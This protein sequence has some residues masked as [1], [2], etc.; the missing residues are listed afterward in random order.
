MLCCW[1]DPLRPFTGRDGTVQHDSELPSC[2]P[3][4]CGFVDQSR[5]LTD[6]G[7][8]RRVSRCTGSVVSVQLRGASSAGRFIVSESLPNKWFC[9]TFSFFVAPLCSMTNNPYGPKTSFS[10]TGRIHFILS[11]S[12]CR[13]IVLKS[14]VELLRTSGF[15][16]AGRLPLKEMI[17]C[18]GK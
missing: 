10:T 8:L 9:F 13:C 18:S 3:A 4:L 16:S 14:S 12:V 17:H 1:T 5:L 15:L 11:V 7:A 6:V 2:F